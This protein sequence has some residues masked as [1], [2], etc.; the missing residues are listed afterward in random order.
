MIGNLISCDEQ[1]HDVEFYQSMIAKKRGSVLEIGCGT[2]RITQHLLVVADYVTVVDSAPAFLE[3]FMDK[4]GE[5][6]TK[7]EIVC[8]DMR[9]IDLPKRYDHI[10]MSYSTFQYLLT[11][12]DQVKTLQRLKKHLSDDGQILLDISPFIAIAESQLEY[13]P[14]YHHYHEV[15]K[16]NITMLTSYR[17]DNDEKIQYWK[18]KYIINYTDESIKK[19]QIEKFVHHLALRRVEIEEMKQLCQMA[20]LQVKQIYGSYDHGIIKKDSN[21]WFFVINHY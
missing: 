8:S 7:L 9:D 16:A 12:E 20:N 18:D 6:S 13:I 14:Y 5:Q 1:K 2:G 17:I 21:N 4:L 19:G 3:K 11:T 10:I 15:L